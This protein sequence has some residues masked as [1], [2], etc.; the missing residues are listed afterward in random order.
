MSVLGGKLTLAIASQAGTMSMRDVG[1]L[2]PNH[3][4]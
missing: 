2:P 4:K 3:P 1:R